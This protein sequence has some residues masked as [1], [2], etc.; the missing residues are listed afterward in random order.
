VGI[1]VEML[2]KRRG[3]MVNMT[4]GVDGTITMTYHVPTRGLLG[5]RYQFLSATRGLGTMNTLFYQYG[6]L[7]GSISSRARG[8]LVAWETGVASTFGLKNAEERGILFIGPGT[9]VYQGMVVGEH[10]RPGDLDINVC[11]TKHLTNM[12]SVIRDIDVRLAT[13]RDMSLDECIEYLSDDELLEVTPGGLR[14]RKRIL[15]KHAR[16]RMSKRAK[17]IQN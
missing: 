2:G 9:E 8:S 12:R 15:D 4:N 6:T 14:I 11:K 1:V 7:A 5:F 10:Q 3:R 13:Q 16:G 17:A